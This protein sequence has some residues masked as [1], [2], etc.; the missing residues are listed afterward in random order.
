MTACFF[1]NLQLLP[2]PSLLKLRVPEE[3]F[4]DMVMLLEFLNTFGPLFEVE[5]VIQRKITYGRLFQA[6]TYSVRDNPVVLNTCELL[7]YQ[8]IK[9]ISALLLHLSTVTI[10]ILVIMTT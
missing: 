4:A 8:L 5:E 10:Y 3:H 7:S 2:K 9:H 6:D 1:I